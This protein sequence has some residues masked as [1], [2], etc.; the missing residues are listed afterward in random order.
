MLHNVTLFKTDAL[1]TSLWVRS[2]RM[3]PR[4]AYRYCHQPSVFMSL[5]IHRFFKTKYRVRIYPMMR[6]TC[7]LFH[8]Y[9]P[10]DPFKQRKIG[11]MYS[12]SHEQ[13]TVHTNFLL[14]NP[15]GNTRRRCDDS[16][17]IFENSIKRG[18]DEVSVWGSWL[19]S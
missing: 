10:C 18:G 3:Q 8:K 6:F 16:R 1:S 9:C 19:N 5:T 11:D 4:M 12:T 17:H 2:F 15:I 13:V 14:E 7:L